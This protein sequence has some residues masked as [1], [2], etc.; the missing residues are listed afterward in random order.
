MIGALP[1][2]S[3]AAGPPSTVS[4]DHLTCEYLNNPQGIDVTQPRLS[5]QERSSK[6]GY[7]QASYRIIVASSPMLLKAGKGNL[8]D[9][10]KV[11]NSGTTLIPYAGAPLM[12]RTQCWW[13]VQVWDT[14]GRQSAWS[15]PATFSMGLLA[16]T[17]WKAT[18]IGK[19]FQ[20]PH[21]ESAALSGARW[22]WLPNA[23]QPSSAA[24]L[25]AAFFRISLR[26][27]NG[28]A[29][30]RA[31]FVGTADDAFT[32]Y[33]NGRAVAKSAD[34][35]FLETVDVSKLVHSGD[36]VLAVQ[37]NNA[38]DSGQSPAGVIGA[39]KIEYRDG[40]TSIIPTGPEW[41]SSEAAGAGWNTTNF[42]DSAWKP[43]MDLGAY[44]TP[45]WGNVSQGEAARHPDLPARYL[46]REF[47]ASKQ[48]L[49]ATAYVCAPGFFQLFVNGRPASDHVMDPALSDFQ[50]ADYYVTTDVTALMRNGKNAIGVVLGNGR[51]HSPRLNAPITQESFGAPRVLAQIEITYKDGSKQTIVSDQTWKMTDQGPIRAN[52]EYDGEIYDARMEMPGWTQPGYAAPAKIWTT[53]DIMPAPGG[54]LIA[55]MI[56]PMRVTR[57]I[58][59]VKITS[60]KPGVYVVDMGQTFYGTVRIKARGKRGTTVHMTSAYALLPDG[61]LK[62]ADNRTALATDHYT[63]QGSGAETWNPI[64]KGQGFRR[65]QVMG[66]PGKPTLDN[67]EGLDEHTDVRPVGSFSCSNDTVNKIHAAMV[68]GMKMFLRSAPLDP[69]RDERQPWMGDPAKDSESEAYNYDVAA[70]YTKWMDDV[71]RSQRPNG[72]IPDLSMYWDSGNGVEWPSVYTIIP[73]W[74]TGFYGDTGLAQ[75]HYESTKRWILN[76][77]EQHNLPDGT[78]QGVGYGDWCDV[79]TIG[80]KIK[81]NGLTPLDLVASAYQYNNLRIAQRTAE[82]LGKTDD[83]TMFR[84]LGDALAKAFLA[85]FY[86]P[87]TATYTSGTQCSYVL[88]L[89][90]GLTPSDPVQ[91]QKIV[92]NLANDILVT[93]DGHLTVG[94]IGNQ[95]LMQV[96]T[97]N[98][99][100]DVAWKLVTQTTR[101][102]WGYM[103]K[104]GAQAIWERWDYDTRDPGMNSEALLIQA[105]NVDAWFYQTLGGI[106]YDPKKPGFSHIVI[107]PQILG[108]LQWVKCSFDS[109]QGMIVSNWTRTG[110]SVTMNVTI[111]TNTTATVTT[112]D[113]VS[114][115]MKSG[116]WV[117]KSRVKR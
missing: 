24:P 76:M 45:P 78:I 99:R 34:W 60:P 21:P 91:L 42:E 36:N 64:F 101:P 12:S 89:A 80:G 49:R 11:K 10:G 65:V 72:S 71:H 87:A 102:S 90:F 51:F 59:P 98:G 68:T 63:F 53:P 67:F 107:K 17:D 88:P 33:I 105:G 20:A 56:E 54:V 61:T 77:R 4:F 62:T 9:S 116:A 108:D 35:H 32:L 29:I 69:D 100:G 79:Y 110:Q 1:S 112:P 8:W 57:V 81:D 22:I 5:W 50:K 93:H 106:H 18:W 117:V 47:T 75:K 58:K 94:L 115:E 41:K 30:K 73:D 16:P 43:A 26:V 111:P 38:G 37:A 55:P 44:G 109:P 23:P 31:E 114:R 7:L 113:G 15:K 48:I 27:P 85:R 103:V 13:A 96:L 39:L 6:K 104:R 74:Y 82:R 2:A 70:F 86:D 52:N 19:A 95:W 97:E 92:D 25:G 3:I 66:F 28:R 40:G 83:I 46:R 84:E 14:S